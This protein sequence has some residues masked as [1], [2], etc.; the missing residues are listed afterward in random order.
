MR[1]ELRQI[2]RGFTS[3]VNAFDAYDVNGYRFHTHEYTERRANRKTTN[4]GVL[5]EGS[6]GLH[7]YGR[8]EGIYELNYG[9]GKGLNPVVFKCQ[10]LDPRRVKRKPEIGLVEVERSSVYEGDDVYILATQAFQVF[11]LPY[12]CKNPKKRLQGWDVVITVPTHN[13]PPKPDQ[14][15]YRRLDPSTYDG[16]FFQEEGLPGKFTINLAT[17]D[18][19]VVD[20]EEHDEV[21]AEDIV[22]DVVEEVQNAQDLTLLERFHAG[23]DEDEPTIPPPDFLPDYWWG[24]DSDDEASGPSVVPGDL[25]TGF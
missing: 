22:D 16:E 5:C 2:A 20:G 4:S 23:L 6:D 10:W 19:M 8:V 3:P 18:D 17:D 9:F 21:E 11:Y 14:D 24:G 13:R 25:E 15:D 1:L 7:Y 12:P